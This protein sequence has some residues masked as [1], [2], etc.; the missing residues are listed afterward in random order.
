MNGRL[1][2]CP[3]KYSRIADGAVKSKMDCFILRKYCSCNAIVG[4]DADISAQREKADPAEYF[5]PTRPN[6]DG[7]EDS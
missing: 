6:R 7:G 2:V 3:G 5:R 1:N 4:G